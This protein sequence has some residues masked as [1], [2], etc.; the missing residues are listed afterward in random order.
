MEK[1]DW[2]EVRGV[3]NRGGFSCQM[4]GAAPGDI[5]ELA[6]RRTRLLVGPIRV[7]SLGGIE[8]LPT[9]QALCSTCY[10]GIKDITR[11]KP[12]SIWLLSQVRRAGQDEQK[13]VFD[14][15]K[16]KFSPKS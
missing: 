15:L 16:K 2:N 7:E 13:A 3:L 5:D 9:S 8:G 10:R 4:C 12:T 1:S 6:G 14:W 11:E